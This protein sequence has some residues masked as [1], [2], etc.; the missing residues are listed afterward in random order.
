MFRVA[1]HKHISAVMA[2]KLIAEMVVPEELGK[3]IST[4]TSFVKANIHGN[5]QVKRKQLV[6]MC[7]SFMVLR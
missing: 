5:A 4:V 7:A 1:K 3:G 2:T 6:E